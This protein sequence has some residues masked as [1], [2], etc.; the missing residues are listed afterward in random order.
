ML[1]PSHIRAV[2][3]VGGDRSRGWDLELLRPGAWAP[4]PAG[5]KTARARAVE[6]AIRRSAL[7]SRH[8]YAPTMALDLFAGIGGTLL[9]AGAAVQF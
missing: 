1:S 6:P 7:G 3:W 2:A 5:P 8:A 9:G 4:G